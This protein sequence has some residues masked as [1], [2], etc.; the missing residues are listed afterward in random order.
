MT[1][2]ESGPPATCGIHTRLGGSVV[3]RRSVIGELSLACT[4]PV[5]DG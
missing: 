1:L 2:R 4:G 3:E 5:A